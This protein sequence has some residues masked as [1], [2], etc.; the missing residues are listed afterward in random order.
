MWPFRSR[1]QT[2]QGALLRR[3]ETTAGPVAIHALA[4]DDGLDVARLV[5]AL[6][7]HENYP[8][9]SFT[10]ETYARDIMAP[11][12]YVDGCIARLG[13]R[14]AGFSLWHPAYDSQSGERGAYMVDLFVIAELR[15]QRLGRALMATAA[16]AATAWGGS[17]LWWSAKVQNSNAMNFSARV[18]EQERGVA[19]WACFGEGFQALLRENQP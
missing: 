2:G 8:P 19:T 7:K 6:S 3:L 14:A 9:P 13:T 18:G 5:G 4:P 1:R 15:G 10:V 12:G 11:D 17:F 16:E